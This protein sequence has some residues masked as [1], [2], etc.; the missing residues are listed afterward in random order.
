LS[1]YVHKFK[2]DVLER[3]GWTAIEAGLGYISV[4]ALDIDKKYTFIAATIL[5]VLKALVAKRI[6]NPKTASTL[7]QEK[8]P[9]TPQVP[10]DEG[11]A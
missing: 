9:A 5:A 3:A 2:F 1:K 6:G 7:P 10:K 8:D 11:G 4:D